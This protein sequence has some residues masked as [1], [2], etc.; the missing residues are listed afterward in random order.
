MHGGCEVLSR[1]EG[2]RKENGERFGDVSEAPV[3]KYVRAEEEERGVAGG[4]PT[5]SLSFPYLLFIFIFTFFYL[6]FS[7]FFPGLI[8]YLCRGA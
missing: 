1:R 4:P 8:I 2:G 3:Y 7:L 6:L 5:L